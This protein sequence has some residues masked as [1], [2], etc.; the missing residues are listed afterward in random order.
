MRELSDE[1]YLDKLFEAIKKIAVED[2]RKALE[3][4]KLKWLEERHAKN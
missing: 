4:A 3:A 1:E 2:L